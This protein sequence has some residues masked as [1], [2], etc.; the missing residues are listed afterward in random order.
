MLRH[1]AFT[2]HPSLLLEENVRIACLGQV[3]VICASCCQTTSKHSLTFGELKKDFYLHAKLNLRKKNPSKCLAVNC[4]STLRLQ[5]QSLIRRWIYKQKCWS[6]FAVYM[7]FMRREVLS[8]RSDYLKYLKWEAMINTIIPF[9]A[10][11]CKS[12]TTLCGI[13]TELN[14]FWLLAK[15]HLP[16]MQII[17][18]Y[19]E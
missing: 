8:T 15:N 12:D 13:P 18:W 14:L 6:F 9:P 4:L 1:F 7:L 19:V 17:P 5:K 10:T 11:Y 2:H 3:D 16:Q